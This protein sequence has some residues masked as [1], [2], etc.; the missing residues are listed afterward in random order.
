MHEATQITYGDGT[1]NIIFDSQ[2]TTEVTAPVIRAGSYKQIINCCFTQ[3]EL[4][5]IEDG[6]NAEVTFKYVMYDENSA[7]EIFAS[8]ENAVSD[9]ESEVGDMTEGII[10]NVESVKTIHDESI[11]LDT[12]SDEFEMQIELPLYLKNTDRNYYVLAENMGS[13]ELMEDVDIDAET[14]SI[15]T[16]SLG[17]YLILYQDN[18]PGEINDDD[19]YDFHISLH[20][21]FIAAILALI[22]LWFLVDKMHNK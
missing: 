18:L 14:L 4:S 12:L 6:T 17:S 9:L 19:D 7:P 8:F 10:I 20:H 21:I 5:D 22:A 16:D 2:S 13:Y 15:S 11:T 1:V 3:K